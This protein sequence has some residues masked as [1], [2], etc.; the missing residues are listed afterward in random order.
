MRMNIVC[1]EAISTRRYPTSTGVSLRPDAGYRWHPELT[2][3]VSSRQ[4][5]YERKLRGSRYEVT[6]ECIVSR[7]ENSNR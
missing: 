1:D 2:S 7:F 4:H 3:R 5:S 6:L